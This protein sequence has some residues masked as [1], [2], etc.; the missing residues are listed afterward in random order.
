MGRLCGV[1][2]PAFLGTL[3]V[4]TAAGAQAIGGTVTDSTGAVLPGVVAEARSAALIEQA[5]TSTGRATGPHLHF[6]I[7]RR[8]TARDPMLYL[9]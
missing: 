3:A 7:R 4:A 1:R 6:E 9:P 8:A 2:V 5:R